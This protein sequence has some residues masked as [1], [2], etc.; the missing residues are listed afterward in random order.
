MS[1]DLISL[2]GAIQRG[3][4]REIASHLFPPASADTA[5]KSYMTSQGQKD[6]PHAGLGSVEAGTPVVRYWTVRYR[7]QASAV[8]NYTHVIA[9]DPFK[10]AMVVTNRRKSIPQTEVLR[11]IDRDEFEA[12][13]RGSP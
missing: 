2:F 4:T 7:H 13:T 11:E 9:C 10:A 6:V 8:W 5:H 3:D 12:L 1:T